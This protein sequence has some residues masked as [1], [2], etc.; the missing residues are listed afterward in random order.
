MEGWISLYRKFR[1]WQWYKD[2]NVKSVFIHLLLSANHKDE[3]WKNKI[4][5]RGQ[6]ITSR[7]HLA[8]A[9][10]LSIQQVRTCLSKLESTNEIKI[11]T[12]NRYTLIT[13]INYDKYQRNI[14]EPSTNKI[15]DTSTDTS[16]NKKTNE[17]TNKKRAESIENKGTE[18]NNTNISTN[19]NNDKSTSKSTNNSTNTSTTNNNIYNNINNIKLNKNKLNILFNYLIYKEK[20]FENL[21]DTDREAVVVCLKRLE[22][23]LTNTTYLTEKMLF[24]IQLQ[25]WTITEIYLSPYKVYLNKLSRDKFMLNYFLTEKYIIIDSEEKIAE[26]IS[27]FITCLRKEFEKM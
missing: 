14:E 27:Y 18:K 17:T 6:V 12:T 15:T 4:I 23:Y 26:F 19:K 7:E 10:G 13:I 21:S 3:E 24:Q 22:L 20:N 25:Y 9:T 8:I 5:K 2:S 1:N 11:E 16:T